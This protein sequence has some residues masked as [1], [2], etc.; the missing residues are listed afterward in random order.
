MYRTLTQNQNDHLQR[1]DES[2]IGLLRNIVPTL[3][4]NCHRDAQRALT[5]IADTSIAIETAR[6]LTDYA[7]VMILF[8][9]RRTSVDVNI[10]KRIQ[11]V[12]EVTI[13]AYLK[14]LNKEML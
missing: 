13:L 5:R 7:V 8:G 3:P 14:Y 1:E 4:C 11:R 6:T 9:V 2:C 12:P 10:C